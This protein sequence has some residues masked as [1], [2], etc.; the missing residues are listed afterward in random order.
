MSECHYKDRHLAG[1]FCTICFPPKAGQLGAPFIAFL[2]IVI[3]AE[4]F[5][6]YTALMAIQKEK[7]GKA[8]IDSRHRN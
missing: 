7:D 2:V 3:I 6:L 4:S 8:S 1:D 5:F